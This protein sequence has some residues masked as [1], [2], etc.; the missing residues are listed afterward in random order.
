MSRECIRYS[1]GY[2]YRLEASYRVQT[3]LRPA[4]NVVTA[5]CS[6]D[7]EGWLTIAAGY[8]W[9]GASGPTID[10]PSSMRPSLVH[11]ALYQ[12]MRLRLLDHQA[13]RE[14]A[15]KLFYQQLV[16]DGMSK[17]RARGWYIGVRT[18]GDPYADPALIS[19]DKCAPC[20]CQIQ[21]CDPDSSA[22]REA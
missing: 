5:W 4:D 22:E 7:T 18:F 9:D 12:L 15:D 16:E 6:L 17:V 11:D 3:G 21:Q 14:H 20:D 13:C 19:P 1:D 10:S 2:K 8:A